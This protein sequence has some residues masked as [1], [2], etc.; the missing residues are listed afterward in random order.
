MFFKDFNTDIGIVSFMAYPEMI[1]NESIYLEKIESIIS[2]G[3]FNFVEI[4]HIDNLETRKKV[5]NILEIANIRVGFDAHTVILAKNLS[6]N[7]VEDRTRYET[8]KILK[9][10]ID[11]AYYFNSE[12]FT[13]L[14]GFKPVK[15]NIELEIKKAVDSIKD[16]C[17]YS[18]YKSKELNVKPLDIIVETFDDKEYAKNR[19]IGPTNL[20]VDFAKEIKTDFNNFGL[21]LDLSHISILEE[22]FAKS[23]KI[24]KDFIKHIH[25]GNCILKDKDHS[26]FGDNHPRFG[27]VNGENDMDTLADFIKAL[28]EIDYFKKIGSTLIF[29]VKPLPGED[30]ELTITGSK[31]FLSKAL[32]YIY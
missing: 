1:K 8:L 5:K 18:V 12:V 19:L 9:V 14:S 21:L 10:L 30:P 20:A 28:I 25:I 2:D 11:E 24:A 17:N 13:L 4:C 31:R 27:I 32:N 29:E 22:D 15:K 16:L 26:A 3:F 6:I 23:L 7:T